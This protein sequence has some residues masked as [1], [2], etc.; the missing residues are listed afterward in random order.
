MSCAR[1]QAGNI[2]FALAIPALL[3]NRPL[4]RGL[5]WMLFG[6]VLAFYGPGGGRGPRSSFAKRRTRSNGKLDV[7]PR[8]E[9]TE[10][11]SLGGHRGACAEA[12]PGGASPRGEKLADWAL[13][14]ETYGIEEGPQG[15]PATTMN[16]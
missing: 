2:Y 8:N 10:A 16:R 11:Y 6:L 3:A 14:V 5:C 4:L 13:A 9:Y 15:P 12:A 1:Y 7:Y